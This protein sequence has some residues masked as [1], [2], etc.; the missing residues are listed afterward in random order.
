MRIFCRILGKC[1]IYIAGFASL[2]WFLIRVIPK[3]SR[4]A[5]PCQRAAFPIASAFLIWLTATLFSFKFFQ[6]AGRLFRKNYALSAIGLLL[7]G[8]LLLAV[9]N[10]LFP[11]RDLAAYAFSA[12]AA[13]PEM[14]RDYSADTD[15]FIDPRATVSLI[16][17]EADDVFAIDKDRVEQMVREAISLAGGLEGIIS[18]GNTVVLKPNMIA[19]TFRGAALPT[20][21]NGMVTDWRVVAAVAKMVREINPSGEILV[22][23]GTSD[24]STAQGYELLKYT[25][26]FIPEVDAFLALEEI[27]GDWNDYES[28]E[29]RSFLLPAETALN[30]DFVLPDG[31]SQYYYN[32]RYFEADVIISLPVLKNHE[33]TGV[34]GAIKNMGIGG[35]P[36]NIYGNSRT[37]NG[38]WYVIDHSVSKLHQFIHDFYYGC[39]AQF[40][41]MDGIQGYSNGPT[42][43]YGPQI[44]SGHQEGMGVIL[45]SNDPVALD[46]I[47][48]L[49]MFD[50]PTLVPHLVH[51]N[52]SSIGCADPMAIRVAGSLVSDL[53]KPFRHGSHLTR[54]DYS[55][56]I[57]PETFIE[58]LSIEN[59]LLKITLSGTEELSRLD[60]RIDGQ[61]YPHFII[62]DFG[63][64]EIDLGSFDITDTLI[65]LFAHD[66]YMNTRRL[67]GKGEK[68]WAVGQ[69]NRE[70]V[71][72]ISVY[73][74]PV[75]TDLML[76]LHTGM[77]GEL[78][79]SLY[80]VSGK[81]IIRRQRMVNAGQTALKMNL[82]EVEPGNYILVVSFGEE[83]YAVRVMK[84]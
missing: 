65:T 20:E 12:H 54:C 2:L 61:Y 78:S 49:V 62:G 34:T 31:N 21:A 57:A 59:H 41:V 15:Q 48:S 50:D 70:A 3:P 77:G 36:S 55:D 75:S 39:P 76:R 17:A 53:K 71:S 29:L 6:T 5:Y 42:W 18:D 46:A 83:R 66:Q 63:N 1:W 58:Q 35:T 24:P 7:A 81:L 79:C 51:L 72:N 4:A 26:E 9:S 60:V 67:N 69:E 73:P 32:K 28:D 68:V 80:S 13:A 45:A 84:Q 74:N 43:N 11:A 8:A 64:V 44:L 82:T 33:S 16:S 19:T 25:R 37:E 27:S 22:I 56:A 38:R 23:E 30:P 10:L 52:N 47:A 14:V 40:A